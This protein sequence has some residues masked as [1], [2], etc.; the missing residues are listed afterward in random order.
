MSFFTPLSAIPANHALLRYVGGGGGGGDEATGG[1][2]APKEAR[3]HSSAARSSTTKQFYPG[4]FATDVDARTRSSG[5]GS[6]GAP[7]PSTLAQCPGVRP[8]LSECGA[9]CRDAAPSGEVLAALRRGRCRACTA[10]LEHALYSLGQLPTTSAA[11]GVPPPVASVRL[12]PEEADRLL[13][14]VER[15]MARRAARGGGGGGGGGGS[16]DTASE[17]SEGEGDSSQEEED[18]EDEGEEEQGEEGQGEEG[19]EGSSGPLTWRAY[20]ERAEVF[21]LRG[22]GSLQMLRAA[23]R[24]V[25]TGREY[26]RA[27]AAAKAEADAAEVAA[28]AE[29][30]SAAAREGSADSDE[31]EDD[32]AID[33]AIRQGA[34][35]AATGGGSAAVG[36]VAAPVAVSAPAMG[37]VRRFRAELLRQLLRPQQLLLSAYGDADQ[38]LRW[39]V[40]LFTD[41]QCLRWLCHLRLPRATRRMLRKMVARDAVRGPP[42]GS[43]AG[44]QQQQQRLSG[45]ALLRLAAGEDGDGSGEAAEMALFEQLRLHDSIARLRLLLHLRLL[46]LLSSWNEQYFSRVQR[47]LVDEGLASSAAPASAVACSPA[48]TPAAATGGRDRTAL[49]CPLTGHQLLQPRGPGEGGLQPG[50]EG[51]ASEGAGGAAR[52]RRRK[53]GKAGKAQGAPRQS[54]AARAY[55]RFRRA[56]RA[57]RKKAAQRQAILD[58]AG[59]Q[60]RGEG[61]RPEGEQEADDGGGD[62][63]GILIGARRASPVA[64]AAAPPSPLSRTA[65]SPEQQHQQQQQQQQMFSRAEELI[66]RLRASNAALRHSTSEQEAAVTVG[67]RPTSAAADMLPSAQ[68]A[69][70]IHLTASHSSRQPRQSPT[71][72]KVSKVSKVSSPGPC[73]PVRQFVYPA[74]EGAAGGGGASAA[75][76]LE[77][78][79]EGA[80]APRRAR[81]PAAKREAQRPPQA[82]WQPGAIPA[83]QQAWQQREADATAAAA[84][85]HQQGTA[86]SAE[87]GS[88]N[89][90]SPEPSP[91]ELSERVERLARQGEDEGAAGLGHLGR[92]LRE[93]QE[94]IAGFD[95]EIARERSRVASLELVSEEMR[96]ARHRSRL[97][98]QRRVNRRQCA[99]GSLYERGMAAQREREAALQARRDERDEQEVAFSFAPVLTGTPLPELL[100]LTRGRSRGAPEHQRDQHRHQQQQPQPP[101]EEYD[102]SAWSPSSS[103]SEL[104][105]DGAGHLSAGQE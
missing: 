97:A 44:E 75:R 95:D 30:A 62:G 4:A 24:W 21:P 93:T 88:T 99:I 69:A 7:P 83:W 27:A 90:L 20:Q 71:K 31:D 68:R 64:A 37:L 101:A 79:R 72:A 53:A 105:D 40:K 36:A 10:G 1:G 34:A 47:C 55:Q 13:Q 82:G 45:G 67:T 43:S 42:L 74:G 28:A 77:G 65:A 5:G 16:S 80:S 11:R 25:L 18:D 98:K 17:S 8:K 3:P 22:P 103:H 52:R 96:R 58:G 104:S 32:E 12:L 14:R 100:G 26:R 87:G 41:E 94:R 59:E 38:A 84:W 56:A 63:G 39:D 61:A 91:R 50:S 60:E 29:A 57:G 89:E 73:V 54:K 51:T 78:S 23:L 9:N 85:Q 33:A 66:A 6:G 19:A 46:R 86:G 81:E 35:A 49:F 2:A 92:M 76:Q 70:A 15:R 48:R 102:V